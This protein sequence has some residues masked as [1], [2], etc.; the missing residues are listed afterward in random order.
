MKTYFLKFPET[1]YDKVFRL[2]KALDLVKKVDGI[3]TA[4]KDGTWLELGYKLVGPTPLPGQ[5]D[6]RTPAVN[7][8]G[9]PFFHVNLRT[10]VNVRNA[11]TELAATDPEMA[12]A[13]AN[14]NKYFLLNGQ[15]KTK[16]PEYPI[17]V[18]A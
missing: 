1:Q 7:G 8:N 9:V 16:V 12:D 17:G 2:A 11:A 13:L 14:A 3:V 10:K 15:G 6:T 5:P 18:F 4:K